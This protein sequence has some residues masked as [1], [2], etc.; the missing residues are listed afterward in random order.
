TIPKREI[1]LITLPLHNYNYGGILQ[2]YALSAF[3]KK[4]GHSVTMLDRRHAT[5]ARVKAATLVFRFVNKGF[6]DAQQRLTEPI[7]RF[8]SRHLPMSPPL[9]SHEALERFLKQ[10][11]FDAL[12]TGSDQVWRAAYA[13][14]M[15]ADL[16]LNLKVRPGVR[17]F[18]YA[19]SFGVDRWE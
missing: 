8:L 19:A 2:A 12:I 9:R 3:L 5:S 15:Y 7:R 17:R 14:E 6:I 1:G 10:R 13:D 11:P 16:F 4:S 18:S